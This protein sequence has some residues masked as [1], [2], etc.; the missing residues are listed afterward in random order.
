MSMT[1]HLSKLSLTTHITCSVGWLGA[2][3]GFLVL[4]I[5]GLTSRDAEVVR[6]SYLSMNLIGLYMI[7]PLSLAAL[8]TGLIQSL[9]TEWGLFRHYWVLTK[10]TLTVG[11]TGLLMLHQFKAVETAARPVSALAPGTLPELGG[12]GT[13]LLSKAALALLTLL[14]TT[15]LSVFKPD[16]IWAEYAAGAAVWLGARR[17]VRF[18][19]RGQCVS[20]VR[21]QGL[22]YSNGDCG[23]AVRHASSPHG[24]RSYAPRPLAAFGYKPN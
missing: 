5:A 15:T 1:P 4:S 14:V 21:I 8:T 2:V 24:S 11:A 3:A 20:P 23:D 7:V 18:K 19:Q 17:R 12:L 16:A 6:G 10:L 9:G 13:E 22:C